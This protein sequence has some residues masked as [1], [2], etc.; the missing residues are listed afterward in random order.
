MLPKYGKIFGPVTI[1][2]GIIGK[3][4]VNVCASRIVKLLSVPV[5]AVLLVVVV[6]CCDV[7]ILLIWAELGF[8]VVKAVLLLFVEILQQLGPVMVRHH[9]NIPQF[10]I[11]FDRINLAA[12]ES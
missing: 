1:W 8:V 7:G 5:I 3:R 4:F 2:I 10:H 11:P 12:S 6:L 9:A